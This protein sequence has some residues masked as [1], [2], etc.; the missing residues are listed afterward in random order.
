MGEQIY[1]SLQFQITVYHGREIKEKQLVKATQ[2]HASTKLRRNKKLYYT[3]F[4]QQLTN[5]LEENSK[6]GG[7]KRYALKNI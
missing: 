6:Y 2:S 4:S 7:R 1:V 3:Q 5:N